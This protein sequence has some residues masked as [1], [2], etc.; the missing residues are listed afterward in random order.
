MKFH[1]L[2]LT[3]LLSLLVSAPAQEH[4]SWAV[5]DAA[6]RL[7]AKNA[8]FMPGRDGF[9]KEADGHLVQYT[10]PEKSYLPDGK[11]WRI[12]IRSKRWRKESE[13]GWQAWNEARPK[14]DYWR[15]GEIYATV[16]QSGV[17]VGWTNNNNFRHRKPPTESEVRQHLDTAG[18]GNVQ[19]STNQAPPITQHTPEE[20][21][22]G[23][24]IGSAPNGGIFRQ[25]PNGTLKKLYPQPPPAPSARAITPFPPAQG[26]I[27][28]PATA[29]VPTQ[30][31]SA[32]DLPPLPNV[33]P[34]FL[35]NFTPGLLIPSLLTTFVAATG[36]GYGLNRKKR[37]MRRSEL[38][39]HRHKSTPPA[40]AS[41]PAT[42]T[43]PLLP[44]QLAKL[45][46]P[47]ER[48]FFDALH[49]V[50]GN[51]W[52]I[53]PKVRLSDLLDPAPDAT[54][55]PSIKQ[56]SCMHVDF[57][58]TDQSSSRVLCGIELTE[59]SDT[60]QN[61]PLRERLITEHFAKQQIPLLRFPVSWTY[62]P[63]GLRAEL[64]KAGLAI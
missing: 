2:C 19:G 35:S 4:P 48:S 14:F 40:A 56:T 7:I 12:E 52:T 41:G 1:A 15:I 29:A 39:P 25:L 51:A 30:V 46:S 36:I 37:L 38:H 32:P 34:S 54:Q 62:Y 8:L 60:R 31:K 6:D 20:R 57:I 59:T 27:A 55:F 9:L 50:I 45:M 5:I 49:K 13:K 17:Q 22:S 33:P 18:Q 64:T 3:I 24:A 10:L 61:E 16:G 63:E 28:A 53:A 47:A 21:R 26:S 58:I 23:P 44:S 43:H 42:N 11:N